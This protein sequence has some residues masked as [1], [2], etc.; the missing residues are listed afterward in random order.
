LAVLAITS[1]YVSVVVAQ[2]RQ[3]AAVYTVGEESDSVHIGNDGDT[4]AAAQE[5]PVLT[6]Q[7]GGEPVESA[8]IAEPAPEPSFPKSAEETTG[9]VMESTPWKP[10]PLR[11]MNSAK[12]PP[13]SERQNVAVYM[14]GEEPVNARGVYNVLGGELVKAINRGDK[15]TAIDRTEAILNQLEKE[16][17]YQRSGAV[18][19]DQIKAIGKQ[20]GA[21]YL[22][23]VDMSVLPQNTFYIDMRLVDVVT[24][25]IV[26][27]ATA[28]SSLKDSKEM[29][30]VA[31][32]IARDL[33]DIERSKEEIK[34]E[35][36]KK[37]VFLITGVTLDALGVGGLA[38]GL[39]E[40][41]NARGFINDK[42]YAAA[43]AA[44]KKRDIA[45][46]AGCALLLG[47]ISIHIFF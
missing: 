24:A 30:R 34:R 9:A 8:E 25:Q 21:H 19:D 28:K 16:H 38:Y 26:G 22:C 33:V 1:A 40:D 41:L 29:I 47:G 14:T 42:K 17:V 36:V 11:A 20:F 31:Q 18:S 3:N 39:F 44:V 4:L 10:E 46:I 7:D 2:D 27:I 35:K 15:Y 23:I 12:E 43:E 6:D 37:R 5:I 32:Q 13:V 45:Y